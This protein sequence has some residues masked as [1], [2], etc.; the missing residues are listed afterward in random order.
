[1]QGVARAT[2]GVEK[3]RL[4]ELLAQVAD[5]DGND[6]VRV[7]L[8]V[9]DGVEQLLAGEDLPRVTE[10]M[11]Q[12]LELGRGQVQGAVGAPG[13]AAGR[14]EPDVAEAQVVGRRGP[15]SISSYANGLTR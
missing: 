11:S 12:K 6:V 14:L 15:A 10:E 5:V 2:H 8:P 3:P 1:M 9:P 4:A 13:G 7:G